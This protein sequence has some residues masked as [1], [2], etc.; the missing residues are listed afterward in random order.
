MA[1]LESHMRV[2]ICTIAFGM[3]VNCKGVRK[4]IH[5]G[6]SKSVEMYVQECGRAGR[7]GLPS[8][9]ILLYNGLLSYLCDNDMKQY[10]QLDGCRRKWLMSH[11]G[12]EV[13]HSYGD[14]VA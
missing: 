1:T 3:G 11:F 4:V 14:R 12:C 5:F 6:P 8:T 2:L 9:C 7:D 10:L 13:D